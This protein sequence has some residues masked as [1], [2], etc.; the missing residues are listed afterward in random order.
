M[1]KQNTKSLKNLISDQRLAKSTSNCSRNY[2]KQ[3]FSGPSRCKQQSYRMSKLEC[4]LRLLRCPRCEHSLITS[5]QES[6]SISLLPA[7]TNSHLGTPPSASRLCTT[8]GYEPMLNVKCT[9]LFTPF[10]SMNTLGKK[11][12]YG[13]RYSP[14]T[15]CDTMQPARL[16]LPFF[17]F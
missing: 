17:L 15:A 13:S 5:I 10:V 6:R 11:K 12:A 9:L 4:L 7:S 2:S 16:I 3:K 8:K 1:E 14:S